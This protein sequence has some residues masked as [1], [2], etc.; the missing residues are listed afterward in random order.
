MVVRKKTGFIF[1]EILISIALI[2]VV[3]LTFLG[4]N[5]MVL[6]ISQSITLSTRALALVKGEIE[7]VRS[8]RDANT[9]SDFTNVNFGGN[10]DY[11]FSIS[12]SNWVRNTGTETV[13][14]F[15]R[16]VVF[17]QV[18]RDGGGNIASSGTLDSQTIKMTATVSWSPSKS[19]QIVDYLTNWQAK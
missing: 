7:A 12:G 2:G 17:D 13:D 3:F 15:S 5:A 19:I 1:L 18:Y 16:K 6:N 4:I 10:N 11:Y 8:F 9:W 14:V